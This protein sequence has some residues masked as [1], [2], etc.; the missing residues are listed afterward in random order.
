MTYK[1]ISIKALVAV[2]NCNLCSVW[3][4][5]FSDVPVSCAIYLAL[6]AFVLGVFCCICSCGSTVFPTAVFELPLCCV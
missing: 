3:R 6:A 4:P 1:R 5:D 2:G